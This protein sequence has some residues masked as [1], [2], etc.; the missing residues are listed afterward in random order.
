MKQESPA[1][2]HGECQYRLK[3][4][5]GAEELFRRVYGALGAD[6]EILSGIPKPHH[7][8]PTAGEDKIRWI[9]EFFSPD[10]KVNIVYREQKPEYCS[11]KDCFLIDDYVRNIREWEAIGGSGILFTGAEE[12]L[13]KLEEIGAIPR[14]ESGV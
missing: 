11:G 10:V 8:V 7:N 12:T 14:E 4:K 6:C 3:P 1:F 13:R 2:R 5:K 9:R